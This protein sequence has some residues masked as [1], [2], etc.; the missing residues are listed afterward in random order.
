MHHSPTPPLPNLV[1]YPP[2]QP[3]RHTRRHTH[4]RPRLASL[5]ST[6]SHY[7][8]TFPL[9]TRLTPHTGSIR[10]ARRRALNTGLLRLHPHLAARDVVRPTNSG[11]GV[12]RHRVS[13]TLGRLPP[14][15]SQGLPQQRADL[16]GS[17]A[18]RCRLTLLSTK[19]CSSPARPWALPT[20]AGPHEGRP[21]ALPH[22]PKLL[23]LV[24][25]ALVSPAPVRP[26]RVVPGASPA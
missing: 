24:M 25:A 21:P 2:G 19:R 14:E 15:G 17:V 11:C 8:S 22:C 18:S 9:V 4:A 6:H 12:L 7:G 5:C 23:P 13:S 20:S 3:M 26:L 10:G 1:R 16:H